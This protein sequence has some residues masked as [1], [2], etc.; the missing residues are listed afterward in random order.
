MRYAYKIDGPV[1]YPD[2][3]MKYQFLPVLLLLC[4]LIIF[5]DIASTMVIKRHWY[6]TYDCSVILASMLSLFVLAYAS[7]RLDSLDQY[8]KRTLWLELLEQF[9]ARIVTVVFAWRLRRHS[10]QPNL[11]KILEKFYGWDNRAFKDN[12]TQPSRR[13][14]DHKAHFMNPRNDCKHN[15][16]G[17]AKLSTPSFFEDTSSQYRPGSRES[18]ARAFNSISAVNGETRNTNNDVASIKSAAGELAHPRP[19][20]NKGM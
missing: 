8:I 18:G 15:Y 2:V 3:S 11:R 12:S 13:L 6:R 19:V 14:N 9:F 16:C 20:Q 5:I 7:V 17:V 10:G 4:V 1:F